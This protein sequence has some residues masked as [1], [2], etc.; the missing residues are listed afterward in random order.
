MDKVFPKNTIQN[1]LKL[2]IAVSD[3]MAQAIDVWS[4]MYIDKADWIDKNV[5]S[6]NLP[7]AIASEIAR[8]VTIE[9]KSEITGSKRADYLNEQ[10]KVVL[11]GIRRYTE[12]GC[13]K[14]GL[15]FKPYIDGDKIA[16]DYVQADCFF[17]ISFDSK[18]DITAAVFV[19]QKTIGKKIYTRLEYHSLT[20][21]D[22]LIKNTAYV[23][24]NKLDL[25]KQTSLESVDDWSG[26]E[27]EAKIIN[28]DKPLFAYFK[29]PLANTIDTSS[30]LGVSIY[31][32][33]VDSIKEADLQYSRLLWEFEGSEL[34]IDVDILAVKQDG[35]APKLNERLFRKLDL[36]DKDK[37]YN[38]FSPT[39]R[40]VSLIN[41]LN[42]LL[43]QIEDTC[44]LARG[45]FSNPQGEAKTAT[46]LKILKQR[47][48]ATV[49]DTQNSLQ[50][51][52]EH[53]IYAMDVWTTIG[54]LAVKGDYEVSFE[55]DDSVIVDADA[56]Q[57]RIQLLVTQGKFPLWRYLMEFEGYDEKTAKEIEAET[58]NTGEPINFNNSGG[59]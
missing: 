50:D 18:G 14:G 11:D 47:S 39:I 26:L 22:Y 3:P 59:E 13:A 1:A 38:V 46:E 10:Y 54:N 37:T 53:L 31:A 48:Y 36:T 44:G 56:K 49:K 16:V 23:S 43:M 27:P 20:G 5:K 9:M 19:E 55:W 42:K 30:P 7:S 41:G 34:A 58:K 28:I 51:A 25:G 21:T 24:E 33:A 17:P 29:V 15:A 2:D 8:L 6:L 4:K 35:T 32:R 52:L 57:N 12:Y 40:D 45:T